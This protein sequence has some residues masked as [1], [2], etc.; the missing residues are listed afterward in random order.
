M[1]FILVFTQPCIAQLYRNSQEV[2]PSVDVY[3]RLNQ[4]W[5]LYGT[6]SA[7]KMD[8]SSYADGAIGIFADYFTFSP[9]LVQKWVHVRK[10]SLPGKFLW[11]RF[12]YQYSAT[13]P[14]AEDPFKE[15]M[16]VT[17]ANARFY[18]P[19][20]MLLTAKNRFDLRF[21]T[22]DFNMRYR[23]RV[24]VERDFKTEFMT[25]T[26]SGFADY[27]VNFGNSQ[28][29]RLRT[30]LGVEI[31]VTKHMNYE[32]FWNHQFANAPEVQEV[33]AFGMAVK[34]YLNKKDFEH[35]LFRKNKKAPETK[36]D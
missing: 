9:K 26:A 11:I 6:A 8:E 35:K 21:E 27:F 22:D 7:T 5:R 15:S 18:L 31:R 32:V 36:I 33:D 4:K 28:L 20:K 34:L 3:L 2:W 14:S 25:F 16:L 24:A 12:G 30:Q 1:V 19:W 23:P 10:D 17:E 13:P 29:N